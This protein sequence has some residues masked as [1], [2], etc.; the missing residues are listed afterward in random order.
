MLALVR[1]NPPAQMAR[2]EGEDPKTEGDDALVAAARSG[3][4]EAFEALVRKYQKPIYF[5]VLRYVRDRDE[6]AD[7]TQ[8]TFIRAFAKVGEL[9][10]VQVFRT[11]LFRIGV[12]LA[13]NYLRDHARFV[14]DDA[15][16]EQI[17]VAPVGAS[18]LE[19]GEETIALR[20]AVAL[21]PTKQRM[22]LEL[23]V[24]RELPF[25]D[26]ALALDTTEGAAKV[27]FH[28]AVRKLR[29]LLGDNESPG[30]AGKR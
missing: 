14:E 10:G 25:R 23:R 8:R 2:P 16:A 24:Y 6:A 30:K 12:N 5:L 28:Y 13:L 20:R 17:P 4:R 3:S 15:A 21:L 19:A 18:R 7:L 9:R 22:T 27:N 1:H 11:W 26:I 29:A